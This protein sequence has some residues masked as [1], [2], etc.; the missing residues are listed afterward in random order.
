MDTS[1][2]TQL[3]TAPSLK[4]AGAVQC[5]LLV[6]SPFL[7]MWMLTFGIAATHRALAGIAIVSTAYMLVSDELGGVGTEQ[8]AAVSRPACACFPP[9]L[10]TG[11]WRFWR[12]ST[13][14]I[15]SSLAS[16]LRHRV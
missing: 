14:Q 1:V 3:T 12:S 16:C 6:R 13:A 10:L 2:V 4:H 8:K 9:R 15:L 7:I 11:D 5:F